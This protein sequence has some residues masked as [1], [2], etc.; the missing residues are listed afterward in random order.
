MKER[1]LASQ[2]IAGDFSA[3]VQRKRSV[4]QI[5]LPEIRI[6]I[7]PQGFVLP[8]D[9]LVQ[10]IEGGKSSPYFREIIAVAPQHYAGQVCA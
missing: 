8:G 10:A 2:G 7:D 4:G 5:I 6:G 9:A 1:S 3:I